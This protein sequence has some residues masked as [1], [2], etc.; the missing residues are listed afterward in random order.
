[1]I[2]FGL[3]WLQPISG[4]LHHQF[5]A[6]NATRSVWSHLHVRIGTATIL[7]GVINGGIGLKFAEVLSAQL[8]LS[9]T[10]VATNGELVAYAIIAGAMYCAYIA[11]VAIAEGAKSV[12]HA[13]PNA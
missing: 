3:V 12:N 13:V 8:G 2:L 10:T 5:F 7:L 1:M 9:S 6:K 11:S 4:I